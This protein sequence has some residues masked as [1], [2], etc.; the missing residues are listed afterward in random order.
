MPPPPKKEVKP[1]IVEDDEDEKASK[2]QDKKMTKASQKRFGFKIQFDGY[3]TSN[4][5]KVLCITLAIII[6]PLEIFLQNVL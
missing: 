3:R 4:F 2:K 1:E 6:I 5:I